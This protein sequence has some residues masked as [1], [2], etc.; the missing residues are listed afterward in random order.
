MD[1][2]HPMTETIHP[3]TA[4]SRRSFLGALSAL[5]VAAVVRPA[6]ARGMVHPYTHPDPRPGIT[7][8]KVLSDPKLPNRAGVRAA[9]NAARANPEIFDGLACGCGCVD[10]HRSLL[11]CYETTQPI[12]C[13]SCREEAKVVGGAVASKQPLDAIRRL[14][15]LK[16]G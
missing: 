5:V 4:L 3:L 2:N 12:G 7:G 6:R 1:S 15:D 14:V 9:Y 10:E 13:F 16:F 11:V 8:E